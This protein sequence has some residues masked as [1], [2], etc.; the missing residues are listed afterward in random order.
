MKDRYLCFRRM[1]PDDLEQVMQVEL[2]VYEFPW[3][4]RIFSDCIRVGYYCWL[5]LYGKAIVGHAVISVVDD[6][7]HML[8]LSIAQAHQ[9]KGYGRQFVEF[10]VNEARVHHA[11]S[12][13]LEV[14]PSNRAA[15]NCYNNAGF[16]EVGCRKD[17]YP[18]NRGR[19]DAILLAKHIAP[20]DAAEG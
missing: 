9:R 5:A 8:N 10:L 15:I 3:T 18:A 17:Y 7:S 4:E 2:E 13:L 1:T 12:M 11:K 6:E 16:N 20:G 14:R 19:E